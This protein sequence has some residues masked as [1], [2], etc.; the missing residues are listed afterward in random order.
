M[1][2]INAIIWPNEQRDRRDGRRPRSSGPPTIAKQ[3]GVIK[4]DASSD[5][6]RTDLAEAAVTELEDEG[7]DVNGSGWTKATV[8]VTEGGE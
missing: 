4:A 8:Q 1:N 2:E 3:F 6:Y 5:A 7:V